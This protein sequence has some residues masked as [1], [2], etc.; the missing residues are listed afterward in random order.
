MRVLDP[1]FLAF[2][3]NTYRISG[4]DLIRRFPRAQRVTSG[5]TLVRISPRTPVH[6]HVPRPFYFADIAYA[7]HHSANEAY[8]AARKSPSPDLHLH[9]PQ[10]FTPL[11]IP[12]R[13]RHR[14]YNTADFS[15]NNLH[16]VQPRQ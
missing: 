6:P 1:E 14:N 12:D 11:P 9:K 3:H 5:S 2:L 15:K 4:C 10:D 7:L 16:G 8:A 13:I